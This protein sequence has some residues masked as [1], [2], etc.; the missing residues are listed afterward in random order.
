MLDPRTMRRSF[1]D[2]SKLAP[3]NPG[4]THGDTVATRAVW[5]GTHAGSYNGLAP[6]GRHVVDIMSLAVWHFRRG[7]VTEVWGLSP[8]RSSSSISSGSC[9]RR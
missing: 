3:L 7:L 6:T 1:L 9:P 5:S 4:E 8:T 2:A